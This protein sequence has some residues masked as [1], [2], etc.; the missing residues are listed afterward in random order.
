M[1]ASDERPWLAAR[2]ALCE[3]VEGLEGADVLGQI[4]VATAEWQRLGAA[5]GEQG[6]ELERRFRAACTARREQYERWLQRDA[7]RVELLAVVEEAER[8]LGRASAPDEDRWRR[9]E[10]RW[11]SI[12]V[13]QPASPEVED[14]RL[15]F[16]GATDRFRQLQEEMLAQRAAREQ[17]NLARV[18]ALLVRL[19]TM[20]SAES[21]K[22]AAVRAELKTAD[23]ALADLGPLPAAE[24][25]SRWKSGSPRPGRS[26]SGVSPISKRRNAGVAGPTPTRRKRSSREPKPCV[27]PTIS[28]RSTRS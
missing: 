26:S 28:R 8:L 20:V 19:E 15:R 25:R 21:V 23:A 6:P 11:A 17:E 5:Q 4:D 14:L 13:P 3:R 7:Q 22:L 10:R 12:S 2:L 16:A 24:R 9:V 27:L 1:R 18:E